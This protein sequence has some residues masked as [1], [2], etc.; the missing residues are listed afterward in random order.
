M[1]THQTLRDEI[2]ALSRQKMAAEFQ[3]YEWWN[4]G[5]LRKGDALMEQAKEYGLRRDK[6]ERVL[7]EMGT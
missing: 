1:D 2:I 6:L 4:R 7:E 3:A 5:D